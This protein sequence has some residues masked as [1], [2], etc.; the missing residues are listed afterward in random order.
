MRPEGWP[1][2]V[3][4]VSG[5]FSCSHFTIAATCASVFTFS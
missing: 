2:C 4:C 3:V 5:T 1:M